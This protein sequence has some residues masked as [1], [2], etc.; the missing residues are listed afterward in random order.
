MPAFQNIH[1]Y[2]IEVYKD[3]SAQGGQATGSKQSIAYD[4]Q[5]TYVQS[6]VVGRVNNVKPSGRPE[7]PEDMEIRSAGVQWPVWGTF[8]P[9]GLVWHVNEQ[10]TTGECSEDDGGGGGEPLI[11]TGGDAIPIDPTGATIPAAGGSP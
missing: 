4:I 11:P 10:E 1:G 8:G 5:I 2:V 7:G 3:G 9:L 6:G